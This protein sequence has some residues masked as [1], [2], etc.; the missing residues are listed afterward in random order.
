MNA[1]KRLFYLGLL[2]SLVT[3]TESA[4]AQ[5]RFDRINCV[6]VIDRN[7]LLIRPSGFDPIKRLPIYEV[8]VA[9][10]TQELKYQT[11]AGNNVN[12]QTSM[13]AFYNFEV[14]HSSMSEGRLEVRLR[15]RSRNVEFTAEQNGWTIRGHL[16]YCDGQWQN[17][18][19]D[20]WL[21]L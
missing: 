5:G 11:I 1:F 9:S 16:N 4:I 17:Q 13:T 3:L 8:T 15:P 12:I 20:F 21:G 10:P 6:N 18:I 7:S 19:L 14:S 2:A